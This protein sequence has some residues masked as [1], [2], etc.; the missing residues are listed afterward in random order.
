[1]TQDKKQ[2][3]GEHIFGTLF[4]SMKIETGGLTSVTYITEVQNEE[5]IKN[6]TTENLI[7]YK[8]NNPKGII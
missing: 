6:K 4:A 2:L 5:N 3:F 7:L 8:S 1:M